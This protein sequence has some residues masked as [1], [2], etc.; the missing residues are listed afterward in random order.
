MAVAIGL[1]SFWMGPVANDGDMGTDLDRVDYAV[2]DTPVFADAE[3]TQTD[4]NIEQSDK[5]YFSNTAPGATTFSLSIYGLSPEVL[6]KHFGGTLVPGATTADPS[7]WKAPSSKVTVERSIVA[8]HQAGGYLSIVRA[9]VAAAFN[10]N[11]Q[12]NNLPQI[13]LVCT[14]LTPTKNGVAPFEFSTGEFVEPV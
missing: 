14:V 1:K 4:F 7:V 8:V 9:S 2:I 5:P 6:Y 3:G 10:W 12:K 11:F 13:N